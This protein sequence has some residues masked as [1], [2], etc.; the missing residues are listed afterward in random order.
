MQIGSRRE[1]ITTARDLAGMLYM[2]YPQDKII[3][4]SAIVEGTRLL[5]H[6]K[7]IAKSGLVPLAL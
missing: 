1:K 7:L 2:P 6:D 4:A 3:G 5:T